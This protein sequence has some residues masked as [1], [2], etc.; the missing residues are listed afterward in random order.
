MLSVKD[1]DEYPGELS[2]FFVSDLQIRPTDGA[3]LLYIPK[4]KVRDK[5]EK[6]FIS[7][8]QIEKLT[9]RLSEKYQTPTQV[10]FLKSRKAE[11]LESGIFQMLN[12][13]F[14]DIVEQLYLS[15]SDSS[16]VNAWILVRNL[17]DELKEDVERVFY[18]MLR[19][20]SLQMGSIQ[21]IDPDTNFPSLAVI[22]RTTKSI[23]PVL[24]ND[25]VENFIADYPGVTEQWLNRH[26]D[27]LIKKNLV[28]REHPEGLY[29]LTGYG[30][31]LVPNSANRN[32]TDIQRALELGKRKW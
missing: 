4:D 23:Q 7:K 1:I 27:K 6:S 30:L 15:F 29:S 20:S 14:N 3:I 5:A 19:L 26:L 32:S 25:L 8:K 17:N 2:K 24:I 31:M 18:E 10:I 28:I 11:D 22:L 13:R 16:T 21:W 12:K 9:L